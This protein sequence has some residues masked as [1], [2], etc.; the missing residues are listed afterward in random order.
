METLLRDYLKKVS[1]EKRNLNHLVEQE[2][3]LNFAR[4]NAF[5]IKDVFD[6]YISESELKDNKVDLNTLD[7]QNSLIDYILLTFF[8]HIEK[9]QQVTETC[10][11]G[12]V[13]DYDNIKEG[14][15]I[16]TSII[17]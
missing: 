17:E 2:K 16:E 8:G 7:A 9:I 11:M 3:F 13:Y 4:Q 5:D 12:K 10:V 6:S 15:F 1:F 14:M